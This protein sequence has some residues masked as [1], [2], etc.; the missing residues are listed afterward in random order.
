MQ[1]KHVVEGWLRER[2]RGDKVIEVQVQVQIE[3]YDVLF[4]WLGEIFKWIIVL[5][6][7]KLSLI[8]ST[9]H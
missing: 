5:L 3:T 4:L 9:S 7:S 8:F 2:E 1:E 6:M